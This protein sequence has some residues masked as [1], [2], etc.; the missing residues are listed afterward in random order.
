M[1]QALTL[2]A[3]I[4]LWIQAQ[5]PDVIH[6]RLVTD[7][8]TELA[9]LAPMTPEIEQEV[10]FPP[11]VLWG[12]IDADAE[13][14]WAA[15]TENTERSFLLIGYSPVTAWRADSPEDEPPRLIY[16]RNK[17]PTEPPK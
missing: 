11:T 10:T 13:D 16:K 1:R 7:I 6:D 15:A 8:I 2:A 5:P 17:R 4:A 12:M 3:R 14:E 9:A